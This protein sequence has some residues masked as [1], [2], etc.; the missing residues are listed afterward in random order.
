MI[1][2]L[3]VFISSC[4]SY[5]DCWDPFFTL[6]KKYWPEWN[7][8]IILSTEKLEYSF[9]GLN[10]KCPC[11]Q[12]NFKHKLTWSERTIKT[13]ELVNTSHIL[14]LLEDYFFK[15]PV[16]NDEFNKVFQLVIKE[17]Y[18]HLMLIGMPGENKQS[19]Y[20]FLLERA[21]NAPYRLSLQAGLWKKENLVSYLRPHESP[22][23]AEIWGTKRAW[24]IQDSF[25]SM[26]PEY[27]QKQGYIINYFIRGGVTRGKWLPSIP[28]FFESQNITNIDYSVRGFFFEPPVP[29]I[30]KR[31]INKLKRFPSQLNSWV[32]FYR[33]K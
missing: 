5:A 32:V 17:D 24:G 18:T 3:T 11:V 9:K 27:I 31:I 8:T 7:G 33:T 23:M 19:K 12:K 10:I 21:Q 15:A 1:N 30:H 4:D 16:K 22:W 14:F 29:P 13:L 28:S 25:Y 6:F 20:N 26:N 2:N